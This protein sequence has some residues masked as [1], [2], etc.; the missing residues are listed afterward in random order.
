MTEI[1]ITGNIV[2]KKNMLKMTKNGHGYYD[3]E[4]RESLNDITDQ[5]AKQWTK[6]DIT[7]RRLPR[8]PLVHPA[9]AVM[10][11]VVSGRSDKDNK[12][13]TVLDALV[14]GGVLKDDCI[15]QCNGPVL[16]L[17]AVKT[18]STAGVKVFIQEDGDLDRLMAHCKRQDW[19]DY[20][21]LRD[22]R[23]QLQETKKKR[24]RRI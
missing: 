23:T 8:A 22:A 13:T 11:Y 1:V 14:S 10:F 2:S 21:W 4:V 3:K 9:I 17:E 7:G 15:D 20:S 24:L 6:P 19:T 18:P 5:V 16:L 12:Y